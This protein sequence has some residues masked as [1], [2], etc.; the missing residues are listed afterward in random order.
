MSVG[1]PRR[2]SR[3]VSPVTPKLPVPFR[4]MLLGRQHAARRRKPSE[5]S[6][7]SQLPHLDSM[8][9]HMPSHVP[10]DV[11][12][13]FGSRRCC[14]CIIFEHIVVFFHFSRGQPTDTY[15]WQY[16]NCA[17]TL[18]G[19]QVGQS[20]WVPSPRQ[21]GRIHGNLE[22]RQGLSSNK[23]APFFARRFHEPYDKR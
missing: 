20:T 22:S 15:T 8:R 11:T 18:R 1:K 2:H 5:A 3:V 14:H 10:S 6:R 7:S 9:S 4:L 21:P 19:V 13:S 16:A 23:H 17:A 12:T